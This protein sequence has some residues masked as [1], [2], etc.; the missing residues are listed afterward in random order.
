MLFRNENYGLSSCTRI[1]FSR[2]RGCISVGYN[3]NFAQTG[4]KSCGRLSG[5]NLNEIELSS[6]YNGKERKFAIGG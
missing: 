6:L 4:E 2:G 5:G 1:G 3:P